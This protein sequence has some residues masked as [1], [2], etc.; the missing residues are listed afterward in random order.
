MSETE[1]QSQRL[2][3]PQV[4]ILNLAHS[5]LGIVRNLHPLGIE[6]FGITADRGSWGNQTRLAKVIIGPDSRDEPEA[7]CERLVD[8]AHAL[9][10]RPIL[11]ATRDYDVLFLERFRQKL[12]QFYVLPMPAPS[13]VNKILNKWDS[14]QLAK[15]AGV[16]VPST[17]RAQ[18]PEE[19]EQLLPQLPFPCVVKPVSSVDWRG[20]EGW[21][22]VGERKAF[23]VQ[24]AAQ[25][26]S[27][28]KT[29]CEVTPEVLIQELVP[30]PDTNFFVFGG[31]FGRD[32][33]MKGGFI[34]RK[35]LQSP[36]GFGTGCVVE[37][38]N[39][40]HIRAYTERLLGLVS[41]HGMAEAE[42]KLDPRDGQY[43]FIEINPRH[44][45]WHRLGTACG[46]NL[47]E[48]L[49]R[50]LAGE[51]VPP[52]VQS[53]RTVKWIAE[54]S[55]ILLGLRM[56]WRKETTLRE[57]L[58]ALRGKRTYAFSAWNDP[59]PALSLLFTGV[60]SPI[61]RRVWSALRPS[62]RRGANSKPSAEPSRLQ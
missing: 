41:Y 22:R 38:S 40:P 12:E 27:E 46:V 32:S 7:L 49:Y 57:L 3:R 25:L 31:Y 56:L 61:W 4:V 5:G 52:A 16:P 34:A 11:L 14:V 51:T 17:F 47:T 26:L 18:T 13:L 24:S 21:K 39:C 29:L 50:D 45:D 58:H 42:F 1:R 53:S 23:A 10:P 62:F 37:S 60:L 55:F 54:D 2:M 15:Q 20:R 48:I 9:R 33:K 35:V 43:K 44:W 8:L 36:S 59:L 30:G 19:L 28:Y 6:I